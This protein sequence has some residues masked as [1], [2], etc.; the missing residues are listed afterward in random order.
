MKTLFITFLLSFFLLQFSYAQ[1]TTSGTNIYNSNTGNVGIGITTPTSLL[2][3]QSSIVPLI[4]LV[5]TGIITWK[6]GNFN[7]SS[8]DNGFSIGFNN[9][10]STYFTTG[11]QVGI[12]TTTPYAGLLNVVLSSTYSLENTGG[13]A[14]STGVNGQPELILGS[15]NTNTVSYIQSAARNT[16]FGTV[17]LSLQPNAG[18]VLIGKTTQANSSYKL[19]VA[20][21][22]R[23]N[24]ITVNT[25]GADFVFEPNYLLRPLS[26]LQQY[27][28]LNH[29]LPEI[30]SA[31]QMQTEGLNVGENETKLL[32]KVEELTL[33]LIELEKKVKEQQKEIDQLKTK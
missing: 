16:S 29:H 6:L 9:I 7:Q 18:N 5:K 12:G 17:P 2:H 25:T 22:V 10:I 27:I 28:N 20:G 31:K 13:I 24:Q 19:D 3:L 15:D 11:G 21:N 1:W 23:V 32:Q 33:Y 26:S 14:V 30:A 8:S 4:S